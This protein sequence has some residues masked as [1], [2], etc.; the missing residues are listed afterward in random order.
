[1]FGIQIMH[2]FI[3]ETRPVSLTSSSTVH[4]NLLSGALVGSEVVRVAKTVGDLSGYWADEKSLSVGDLELPL[5]TTESWLPQG[6]NISGALAWGNTI[7]QPGKVGDEYFMTRGHWHKRRE[8]G[9][10]VVCVAGSGALMLMTENRETRIE[11]LTPNSTHHVPGFTAHRTVNT[12][13]V[14]LVFLC[15]WA[16]DCGHDYDEIRERGFSSL[17]VEMNAQPQLVARC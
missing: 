17:F 14:P 16:A 6:E 3:F 4:T 10:L 2:D 9:E 13:S 8:C 11:R 7:L 15:A 1:M 5:Y 12:G